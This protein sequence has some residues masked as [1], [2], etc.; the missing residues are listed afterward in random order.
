VRFFD[1]VHQFKQQW[2]PMLNYYE[3]AEP[4]ERATAIHRLASYYQNAEP[5]ARAAFE[6]WLERR[7]ADSA[8]SQLVKD[9]EAA[10][11]S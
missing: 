10:I 11:S 9:L 7:K 3:K 2:R 8:A 4:A 1:D 5:P 6:Q